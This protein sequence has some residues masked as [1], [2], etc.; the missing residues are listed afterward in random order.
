[1]T[2]QEFA[3]RVERSGGRVFIVGG[4]VRDFLRK[5]VPK[6]K[7]YVVVGMGGGSFG[8]VFPEAKL[9]GRGFPVFLLQLEGKYCE[10]AMA[11]RER[12]TGS[13]YRGFTA[14]A[15]R[16]ITIQE[17]LYRRDLTVNSMAL[18][19]QT[20]EIIDS[21]GGRTDLAAGVLRPVSEHFTEDPVRAL[22]GARFAAQLQFCP[23]PELLQ[24]MRACRAELT[25]EPQERLLSEFRK[26][27]AAAKPS[28]FFRTLAQADLLEAAFPEIAA[29]SGKS[30]PILYHPEGDAFEHTMLIA[31]LTAAKTDNPAARFAALVH[32][33]GKGTTPQAML[34][35]HYGHEVRGLEV[36]EAWNSRMT[37]PSVWM[38][39]ASF[40]IREHMRA[41]RLEKT[42][43][44]LELLLQ[45]EKMSEDISL[46]DM[47]I[48]IAADHKGLPPYLQYAEEGLEAVHRVSGREAPPAY[49]GKKIG[50][51]V[52][53]HQ[54]AACSQWLA[55]YK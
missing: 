35:H 11:R 18:D 47:K 37:L 12:K 10:V 26:A 20:G 45:M 4:W 41:P 42:A 14:E 5:A 46:S 25:A 49:K 43:K 38:R 15:D 1:M 9:I 31:D 55:K 29:L 51:W 23:T 40:M 34:P 6:D 36:L 13:G 50:A 48:I 28:L 32:D 30:Q 22:R 8:E 19:L 54:L 33:L 7:D 2:E 21:Y 39:A 17:D 3:D 24:A 27:L 52:W 53:E 44:I 16:S